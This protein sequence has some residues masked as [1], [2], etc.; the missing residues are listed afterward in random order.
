MFPTADLKIAEH[1][2]VNVKF[3][4]PRLTAERVPDARN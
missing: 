3:S 2:T 4:A 1:D